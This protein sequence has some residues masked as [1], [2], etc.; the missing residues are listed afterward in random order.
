VAFAPKVDPAD[1]T[2][3]ATNEVIPAINPGYYITSSCAKLDKGATQSLTLLNPN[4]A[5]LSFFMGDG[6]GRSRCDFEWA[7]D[8][9][10][11]SY[12]SV[13]LSRATSFTFSGVTC[14]RSPCCTSLLCAST[15]AEGCIGLSYTQSFDVPGVSGLAAGVIVAIVLGVLVAIG[16]A[17]GWEWRRRRQQKQMQMALAM[18]QQQMQQQQQ[19]ALQVQSTNPLQPV[20]F[21]AAP[22]P[23]APTPYPPAPQGAVWR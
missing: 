10:F 6:A 1:T 8:T 23:Y 17:A 2:C 16:G 11:Y 12:K 5:L 21:G 3:G 15:N 19:A 22:N 18:Q 13:Q 20:V 9:T 14:D 7:P 4:Q